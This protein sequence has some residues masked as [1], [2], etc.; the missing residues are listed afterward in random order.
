[1]NIFELYASLNLDDKEYNK[2]LD[3]S[4]KNSKGFMSKIGTYG[5][6]A[7]KT[8]GKASMVVGGALAGVGVA[9]VNIASNLTEV[10]NVTDTVFGEM[11]GQIDKWSMNAISQFGLSEL[12]AKQFTGTLGALLDSSGITGQAL[13]D[14][15]TNLAGLTGDFASFYNL[16]HEEA[17]E[18]IKS[19]IAGETEP[20]K[21]LGINMSVANMEAF[22]LSKGIDKAWKSMTQAE[23]TALR[24]EYIMEKG[25]NASGDFAKTLET[26]L[27]NQL[28][29]ASNE[30]VTVGKNIGTA[31]LPMVTEGIKGARGTMEELTPSIYKVRDGLLEMFNGW[32]SGSQTLQNGVTEMLN[33]LTEKLLGAIPNL[34]QIGFAII[35]ALVNSI[36][37]NLPTIIQTGIQIILQLINGLTQTLPELIP[38]AIQAVLDVANTLVDNL[39]LL[40]DAGIELIFALADGLIEALPMLI[41]QAPVIINKFYNKLG[42]LVPK[43]ISQGINLI[44]KLGAGIIQAIPTLIANMGEVATAIFNVVSSINL[45]KV[46]KNMLKGLWEGIKDT[47]TWLIDKIKGMGDWILDAIKGVFG[48]KSPSKVFADVVGKNLALGI[49]VG[50]EDEMPSVNVDMQKAI[51]T[52]IDVPKPNGNNGDG[53]GGVTINVYSPTAL[54]PS[55]VASETK[56]SLQDL[57]FDF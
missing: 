46:G 36:L 10:Q 26:S 52:D 18:K 57:A 31:F 20:L 50:F 43:L 51:D 30:F 48:I 12:Q 4:E 3:N 13:V 49:G 29:V 15:S 25:A 27:A 33:T 19:G 11:S 38:V 14:M 9:S 54:N 55:E 28:R 7:M 39:E 17:F 42:E 41:E 1:M 24:Y 35:M 53:F 45:F 8:I 32:S 23:Q 2:A 34:I 22:A 6:K 56:K 5:G 40:V 16:G 37:Q 44:V 21:A 47:K